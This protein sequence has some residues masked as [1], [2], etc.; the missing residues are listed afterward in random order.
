MRV[1]FDINVYLKNILDE[2]VTTPTCS[3]PTTQTSPH[4]TRGTAA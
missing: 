4:F 2:Q 3:L 1:V